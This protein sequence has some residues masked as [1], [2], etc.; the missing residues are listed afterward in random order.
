MVNVGDK[1]PDFT[2]QDQAGN[3]VG[4]GDFLGKWVVLYFY[5]KDMTP[6]CTTEACTF[7]DANQ[8]LTELGAVVLGVS[9]DTVQSH[10]KM[11]S[12]HSLNFPLLADPDRR[13]VDAYGVWGPKSFMGRVFNGTRRMTYIINP[14]GRI[15]KVYLKVKAK[16]HTEEVLADLKALQSI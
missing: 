13:I 10:A 16:T 6:G 1:A 11:A 4:L 5:P 15:A 9:T 7:R 3:Q 2:T 12:K 14:E 8:A